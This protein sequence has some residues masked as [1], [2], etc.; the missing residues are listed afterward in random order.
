MI[1]SRSLCSLLA[2]F[3]ISG[4]FGQEVRT[5]SNLNASGGTVYFNL[6]SGKEVSADRS[7]TAEWDI[8][9][10]KTTIAVNEKAKVTAQVVESIFDA[11]KKA[12]ANGYRPD[13]EES[14]AIPTGSGNGWYNYNMEDHSIL[15]IADRTIV[16]K[17]GNGKKYKISIISYNKDQ[18]L[19]ESTGYYTFRY[20]A[21]D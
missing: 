10:A 17:A 2:A 7:T 21:I 15:P 6:G 1:L 8:S 12:P 20:V 5:I 18:K 3:V 14:R 11:L 9:F 13:T 4:A 16:V 19:F